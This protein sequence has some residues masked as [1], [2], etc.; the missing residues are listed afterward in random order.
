[1]AT[2]T[3]TKKVSRVEL[4]KQRERIDAEIAA[5]YRTEL[6]GLVEQFKAHL[7]TGEFEL[8][9]ALALL[10]AGKKTHAKG[11]IAKAKSIHDKPK[12]GSTYKH[13]KTGEEW[14]APV[15]LRRVKKWLQELVASSGK[16]YEDFVAKK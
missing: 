3:A 6:Q 9:D 16:K 14:T 12:P 15:N 8:S 11:G 10:G 5:Q 13:P 4:L 7:K 1:M 2:K